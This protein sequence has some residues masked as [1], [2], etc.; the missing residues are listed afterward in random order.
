M[1]LLLVVE[2]LTLEGASALVQPG[3]VGF[4]DLVKVFNCVPGGHTGSLTQA[5]G[6]LYHQCQTLVSIAGSKLG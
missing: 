4:V 3:Y 5:V 1:V 2:L 6:S